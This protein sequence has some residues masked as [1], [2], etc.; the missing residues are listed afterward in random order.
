MEKTGIRMSNVIDAAD[1][2]IQLFDKKSEYRDKRQVGVN[3]DLEKCRALWWARYN[4]KNT[5]FHSMTF[6]NLPYLFELYRL[7]G[8]TPFMVVEKSVQCGLSELF[9][10]QSHVEA[11]EMGLTVMYVLPKYELRNRFVNNRIYKLHKR[12]PAYSVLV[13][14]SETKVHRTSLMHFGTGT[15]A[16]VGSN[17]QDEFIEIP[18]DSAYVDEKD[19]CNLANL[20]MLPDRLTA[21]PYGFER[22][23]GNPTVEGFG[24]DERYAESSQG[25]WNL[26]CP[27]CNKWFVPDFFQ[28]V[29]IE[30]GTNTFTPRDRDAD[31]DPQVM[32]DESE[33]RLIHD[34]GSPVNRLAK[35]EWVSAYQN[36]QWQGFRVSQV[37]SKFTSLR[38]L[39]RIW[40]K[41]VGNALK[42][43]LFYNSNLGLPFASRGSKITRAMLQDCRRNYE[44]PVRRVSQG[45]L[46]FMG[47]DV[48]ESIHVILRERVK[49][50]FGV[51]LRLIGIWTLPGFTQLFQIMREWKPTCCVIDAQP[52]IHKIMEVKAAFG[53][54]WSSRFQEGCTDMIK[55]KDKREVRMD[56]TALLDYVQQGIELKSMTVPLKAESLEDGE[57][58]KQ[59][60]AATRI[61]EPNETHPEKSRFVWK[62]GSRPDHFFLAEGY[63]IQAGMIM[64]EH[65]VFDFFDQEVKA[66]NKFANRQRVEAPDLPDEKRDE[67]AK[68]QDLTPQTF[69]AN[70]FRK[71]QTRDDTP[72]VNEQKVKDLIKYNFQTQKYVDVVLTANMAQ[73]SNEDVRRLLVEMGFTESRIKGQYIK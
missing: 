47:V 71:H 40:T 49:S 6:K 39:Y 64:P 21:S 4:H 3:F 59:M 29:V 10:I 25:K 36:R 66:L 63:C 55:H 8:N 48:G 73:E 20:L 28:H 2:R 50:Q 14:Q 46:R 44:W 5:R 37:F 34:C 57:Y 13:F 35:G 45:R 69:L 61:L 52:E 62:E 1:A 9:I 70:T 7:I 18:V 19:R 65:G 12:A 41:A 56:R 51:S 58:Y 30:S 17:V 42:T 24:I 27:S 43:Q 54:A 16:Y 53:M 31:P 26:K 33:F 60:Q 23:I 11:G 38:K 15:L 32:G 68:L 72:K 22:E 67:I